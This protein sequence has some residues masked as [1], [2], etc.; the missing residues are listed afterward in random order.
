MTA[1][2][3]ALGEPGGAR[4]S[5]SGRQGLRHAIEEMTGLKL[6]PTNRAV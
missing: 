3:T 6:L 4:S 2:E 5:G 1:T